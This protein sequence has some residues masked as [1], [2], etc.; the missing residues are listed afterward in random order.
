MN[1]DP[2]AQPPQPQWQS[3]QQPPSTWYPP[4]QSGQQWTPP[5]PPP[6]QQWQQP[7]YAQPTQWQ[8]VPTQ[9]SPRKPSAW[10]SLSKKGKISVGCFTVVAMLFTCALC[11][12]GFHDVGT[13]APTSQTANIATTAT[14]IPTSTP[15]TQPTPTA[16]QNPTPTSRPVSQSVPAT[17]PTL[18]PSPASQSVPTT[19]PIPTPSPA[20]QSVP[21]TQ[22][23]PTPKPAV[24]APP[25]PTPTQ[26]PA[27]PTYNF[28]SS[29]GTL[30]YN[31][32]ANFCESSRT[33]VSTFWTATRG[34]VVECANG[35]YSHSG[36]ISGA[37][38]RDGGI[39]ATLYRH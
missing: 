12:S 20:S 35:K 29:G 10:Q 39:A 4:T 17:L 13:P 16:K 15:I 33:C 22:P 1:Y 28:N 19:L 11:S 34:Y 21:T 37:C 25:Q 6:P 7:Q 38:S 24:A 8:P 30:V 31:P 5:P 26:P 27:Q 36:G 23:T 9:S 2:N 14:Q 32:P 18:T 3:P